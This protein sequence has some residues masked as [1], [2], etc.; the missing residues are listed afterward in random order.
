M[1]PYKRSARVGEMIRMEV[2][3]IVMHKVKHLSL[4]FVTITGAKITDDLRYATVYLSVL[5]EDEGKKVTHKLNS[6]SSFIRGELGKRIKMRFVPT[7]KF[8]L[9]EAVIYGRKIDKLLKDE[10][11]E[12]SPL[13]EDEDLF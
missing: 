6:M 10:P 2:A 13:A 3:D 9:D 4:G 7:V 8:E 12:G 11:T 1:L 5:N